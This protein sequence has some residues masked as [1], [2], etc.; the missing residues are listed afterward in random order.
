MVKK[1]E[2]HKLPI[3]QCEEC[4]LFYKDKHLAERC[5]KFC[6]EN[7]ACDTEITKYAIQ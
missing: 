2:K 6:K 5:E 1:S 7:S 3:F 4:G